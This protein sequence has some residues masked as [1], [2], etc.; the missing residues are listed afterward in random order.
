[1]S[2]RSN[3]AKMIQK[4]FLTITSMMTMTSTVTLI[5]LD[6]LGSVI[7]NTYEGLDAYVGGK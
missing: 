6:G 5:G 2:Q 4:S 1:M 3:Q 7:N